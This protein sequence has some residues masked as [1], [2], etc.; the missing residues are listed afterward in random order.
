MSWGFGGIWHVTVLSE[1]S[2]ASVPW[3]F[4]LLGCLER[5]DGDLAVP[6][7]SFGVLW[8][9]G[10]CD[11]AVCCPPRSGGAVLLVDAALSTMQTFVLIAIL[12]IFK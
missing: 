7:Q 4:A 5:V 12:Y 9:L 11:V 8:V 10:R 6:G 1:T 2:L 3:N